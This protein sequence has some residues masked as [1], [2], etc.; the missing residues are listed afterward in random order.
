[1][2]D[3]TLSELRQRNSDLS[4][5]AGERDILLA[6]VNDIAQYDDGTKYIQGECASKALRALAELSK[7]RARKP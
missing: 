2:T 3:K 5:M 1:M 7:L 4:Y 6:A